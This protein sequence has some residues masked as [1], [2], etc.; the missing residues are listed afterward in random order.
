[1]NTVTI[2]G[3]A[4]IAAIYCFFCLVKL[5]EEEIQCP[6]CGQKIKIEKARKIK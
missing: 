4:V 6:R 3:I 5:P 2:V 1:M